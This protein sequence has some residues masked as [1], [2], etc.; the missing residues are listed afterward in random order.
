MNQTKTKETEN[1]KNELDK[2]RRAS[3]CHAQAFEKEIEQSLVLI[4]KRHAKG[5]Q[6]QINN[7]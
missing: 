1:V 7:L 3:L 6:K 5:K 4:L 2:G